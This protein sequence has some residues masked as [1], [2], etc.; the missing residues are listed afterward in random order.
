MNTNTK[1]NINKTSQF[2]IQFSSIQDFSD[3][4]FDWSWSKMIDNPKPE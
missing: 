4:G 1:L 2:D 3:F